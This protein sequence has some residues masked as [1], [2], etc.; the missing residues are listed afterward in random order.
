MGVYSKCSHPYTGGRRYLSK[1]EPQRVEGIGSPPSS[2]RKECISPFHAVDP[3]P[4]LTHLSGLREAIFGILHKVTF[5]STF[6]T[7]LGELKMIAQ[8]N[9]IGVDHG[10]G[11]YRML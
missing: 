9:D 7:L 5:R 1:D 10:I 3:A 6:Q 8:Q 4:E 11:L 2:A